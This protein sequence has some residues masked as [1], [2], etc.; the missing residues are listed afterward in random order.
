MAP[1]PV[2]EHG[3][4]RNLLRAVIIINLV[5]ALVT[6]WA[7]K[8][9]NDAMAKSQINILEHVADLKKDVG[10]IKTNVH[11][12]LEAFTKEG[13]ERITKNNENTEETK[14]AVDLL[15]ND[16]SSYTLHTEGLFSVAQVDRNHMIDLI[17]GV[18]SDSRQS[19]AA[20]EA[21]HAKV[22][23]KIVTV[24]EVDAIKKASAAKDRQISRL[25]KKQPAP[26]IKFWPWQ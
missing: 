25:K 2:D 6:L 4:G 24:P 26:V 11:D 18:Q 10:D 21:V 17:K 16:F 15:K 5:L 3:A 8:A 9:F 13:E 7:V 22:S 1:F 19:K 12:E 20:S 23:Q 14:T